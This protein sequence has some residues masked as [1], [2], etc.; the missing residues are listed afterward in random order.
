MML[1][2]LGEADAAAL[3]MRAVETVC[4]AGVVTPDLGG[5]AT[6]AEVTRAVCE[7]V[8]GVNAE[9]SA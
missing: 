6:T 4:A 5:N 2:H 8:R 7:A 9:P 3:L 1:D